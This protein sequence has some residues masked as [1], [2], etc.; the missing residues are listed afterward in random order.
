MRE[1]NLLVVHCAATD[2]DQDIGVDEI[3][4]MHLARG[5]NDVGYHY[6]IKRS[7]TIQTGRAEDVIGA[8]AAGHNANSIG[9]CLI[10]GVEADDKLR[11]E[12]NYTRWQMHSLEQLLTVLTAKYPGAKVLGHRDLPNVAKACPCFSVRSWWYGPTNLIA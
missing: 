2:D 12:F 8:H 11:A 3:R 1:I 6:V 5:F 7:G 4:K 9:V 10:G